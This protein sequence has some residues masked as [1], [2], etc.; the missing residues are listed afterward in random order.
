VSL[1][2]VICTG[3]SYPLAVLPHRK[4]EGYSLEHKTVYHDI[5]LKHGKATR[6]FLMDK[7]SNSLPSDVSAYPLLVYL[8]D[9]FK[10]RI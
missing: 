3:L 6:A 4:K 8:A 7:V 2:G 10:A 5:E 1:F 9:S